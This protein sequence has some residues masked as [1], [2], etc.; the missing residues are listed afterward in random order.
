MTEHCRECGLEFE[1]EPGYWVGAMIINTA[2][3]FA[4]FVGTFGGMVIFTWPDVPWAV[5]LIVTLAANLV[6]P[7]V[8]YPLSKTVWLALEMTWHP[9]EPDEIQAAAERVATADD[10]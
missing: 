2:L 9:L 10:S 6:I 7:A 3:V 4:T 5:V 1:R 8:L